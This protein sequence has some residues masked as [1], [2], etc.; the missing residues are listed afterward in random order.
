MAN[1]T[2]S[3]WLFTFPADRESIGD[4]QYVSEGPIWPRDGRPKAQPTWYT[5]V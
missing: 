3:Y 2:V 1:L 5:A 4:V